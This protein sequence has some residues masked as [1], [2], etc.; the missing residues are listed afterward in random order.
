MLMLPGRRTPLAKSA[1]L[2][3]LVDVVTAHGGQAVAVGG[4]VR[5]HLLGLPAKDVDVEVKG[6]ALAALEAAFAGAGVGVHAVGR[7]FGVLKVDVVV[8]AVREVIDV[9]LPRTESKSGRGHKGFVVESDPFLSFEQAAARRDFTINAIGIDLATGAVLDPWG[10]VADLEAGVLRHVSPAFDEDPLRVLRAAQFAA[11]FGLDVDDGTVARCRALAPELPTLPRERVGEELKKLLLKGV[12][13]SVGLSFLRRAGVVAALFPELQALIGC[14]QE[15]EWHPEGDVW[16]HTLL[17]VDEAAR[18]A[19]DLDDDERFVVV[20]GA[21]CH[22]LGKPATTVFEDGRIRSRDHEARGEA[23]TRAFCDRLAV[24]HDVVDAVVATVKDHLKPFQL[25]R[26]RDKIQDSAVRRLALR[27]PLE[28]LVRVATADHFGRTTVEALAH[29]DEAGAWLLDMAHR[30]AVKDAAPRPLLQG[31]DLV[32]RGVK[33]GP[34]MGA[35][36]KESFE[37]QLDGR[38]SDVDGARAWLDAR[39][40]P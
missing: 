28:R 29:D 32:A 40:K 25:W 37:A 38:F 30:L 22:D 33:P 13:P 26:D 31:R 8:G 6:V 7:A 27:V 11:R 15:A 5:D 39:L 16:T 23:P 18:L 24:A 34:Q 19:R 20:L 10:G 21:L 4:A 1:P 3:R 9:A 14:A 36:L 12:W 17:V 35:L 2:Q